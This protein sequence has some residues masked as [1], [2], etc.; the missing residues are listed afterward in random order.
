MVTRV[1]LRGV[2]RLEG[3]QRI[4]RSD[5][6][7]LNS[8][9][10]EAFTERY[11]RD[12]LV[13]VRVP[14]LNPAIWRYAIEDAQAGAMLWR[15]ER[16]AIAAFNIAHQSGVEGWMGPLAVRDDCQGAGHG[17]ALVA[18][19]ISWL[20]N[21]GCRV[22]GLETMPRTM[23]NI[24]F[25]ASLGFVPARLT[26]TLTLDAEHAAGAPELLS[27]H[28][29]SARA[30]VVRECAALVSE[31]LPG[32]DY[33]REIELTQELALGD[34]LVLR[35]G[36]AVVGFALCHAAP[37]LDGPARDELRVLKL[38]AADLDHLA[39]ADGDHGRAADVRVVVEQRHL[40][41]DS[42]LDHGLEHQVADLDAQLPR[43]DHVH[44]RGRIAQLE[45]H[46][47]C[48]KCSARRNV[49]QHGQELPLL[50]GSIPRC[51]ARHAGAQDGI[52]RSY[53]HS[54]LSFPP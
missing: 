48:G 28:S 44:R 4:Q 30:D 6:G 35:A 50:H 21:A 49:G 3:P 7:A 52:L 9:F 16:G 5:I 37:L 53:C 11:R 41:D 24:G 2:R 38:V 1:D 46:V 42:A 19:G 14:P 18:A 36:D 33:T 40:A 47:P 27:S 45:Q 39:L 32:Y 26:V 10:S 15:D 8:L 25:Y 22:I 51:R 54:P 23:D 12:G 13:G 17:K 29:S 43:L 31:A 34:T 20:R